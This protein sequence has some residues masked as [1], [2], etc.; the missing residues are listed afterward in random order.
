MRVMVQFALRDAETVPDWLGRLR[1]VRFVRD[2]ADAVLCIDPETKLYLVR[3][4]ANAES[5]AQLRGI[6]AEV[7][8]D[9]PIA[10]VKSTKSASP[11]RVRRRSR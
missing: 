11:P 5:I 3:G 1:D 6:G 2:S 9:T 8:V 10:P 7:F 4:A